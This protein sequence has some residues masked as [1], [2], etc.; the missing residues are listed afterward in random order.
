[1]LKLNIGVCKKIGEAN[2]GSRGASA[3][4]EVAIDAGFVDKPSELQE[5]I[6]RLYQMARQ[7]VDEELMAGSSGP[8]PNGRMVSPDNG[9]ANGSDAGGSKP[10]ASYERPATPSQ[11]RAIFAIARRQKINLPGELTTRYGVQRPD[12]LTIRD[13]STFIDA[14]KPH[15]NGSGSPK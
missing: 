10:H 4:L 15:E 14:I 6:R 11:V 1:M 3:N 5:R 12:D 13:A 7:S 2:Y 9:H 8:Q